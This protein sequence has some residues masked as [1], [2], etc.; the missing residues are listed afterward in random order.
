MVAAGALVVQAEAISAIAALG[1]RACRRPGCT[2]G[3]MDA[4]AI[5]IDIEV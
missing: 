5:N 4:S 2:L 3:S 1:R